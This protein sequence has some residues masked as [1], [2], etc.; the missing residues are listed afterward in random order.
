MAITLAQATAQVAA[1]EAASLAVAKGQSYT[2][3]D[4]TLTRVHASE[5]RSMINYWSR[6]EATQQR[7]ANGQQST[8]V[9][10]ANFNG[11]SNP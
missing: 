9:S 4:R 6:Q 11:S 10:L 7:L 1:W 5:I 8:G 2:I 3:G